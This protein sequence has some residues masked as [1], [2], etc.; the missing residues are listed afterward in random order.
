MNQ[1]IARQLA[2]HGR[3][4]RIAVDASVRDVAKRMD[5]DDAVGLLHDGAG[6]DAARIATEIGSTPGEVRHGVARARLRVAGSDSAPCPQHLDGLLTFSADAVDHALTCKNCDDARRE[7][8]AGKLALRDRWHDSQQQSI[9]VPTT[10]SGDPDRGEQQSFT[11]RSLPSPGAGMA[12]VERPPGRP[13]NSRPINSRPISPS[14]ISPSPTSPGPTDGSRTPHRPLRDSVVTVLAMVAHVPRA[15]TA[16]VIGAGLLMG[17]VAVWDA[18]A[19]EVT[20]RV[21]GGV[22]DAM[23][24]QVDQPAALQDVVVSP[25]ATA[26]PGV[27]TTPA[28]PGTPS[29]PSLRT[30]QRLAACESSGNWGVNS[31]NGFYGGL[32]FTLDSWRLVGGSGYPHK[33]PALEQIRRAERLLNLQGWVAWPV[34]SEKLGLR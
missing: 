32:Q 2:V 28:P 10:A 13:I 22:Q 8:R 18:Q 26:R 16:A 12:R 30:W 3:V 31:G 4:R 6:W 7:L 23:I 14:P 1:S 29:Q 21:A 17:G 9:R 34:C 19:Q 33:H 15:V 24:Q 25:T 11:D 20:R 5:A 27:I